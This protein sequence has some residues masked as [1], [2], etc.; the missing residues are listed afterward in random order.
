MGTSYTHLE[1]VS[2]KTLYLNIVIFIE[3]RLVSELV[4]QDIPHIE[5]LQCLGRGYL[6]QNLLR[7]IR[8]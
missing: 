5:L 4:F 1:E 6:K 8:L 2:S 3:I 7:A